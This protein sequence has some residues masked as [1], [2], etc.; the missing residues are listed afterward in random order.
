[1]ASSPGWR[2][3]AAVGARRAGFQPSPAA[4]C[5]RYRVVTALLF[6]AL[7]ACWCSAAWL[8]STDPLLHL[9]PLASLLGLGLLSGPGL[10]LTDLG[11]PGPR[12]GALLAGPVA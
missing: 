3:A 5:R 12:L 10:A 4:G 6:A 9:L 7:E 8:A 11:Q 2:G 1:M